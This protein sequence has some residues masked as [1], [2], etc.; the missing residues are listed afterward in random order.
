MED[1]SKKNV[2]E[3]IASTICENLLQ[4]LLS[5]KLDFL[6]SAHKIAKNALKESLTSILTPKNHIDLLARA[7]KKKEEGRTFVIVFI[8]VNGVGKSTNLAKIAY[9]FRQNGFSV[10]LAACDN[11]R[12]GAVEQLKTHGRCLGLPVYDRGYKDDAANIA[13][14]AIMDAQSKKIDVVLVD[15]AGRM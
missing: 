6:E 3:S 1:L 10:Q 5:S 4:Q 11:F 8:G 7:L 14:D 15:T 12:S 9:L 2:A 13:R